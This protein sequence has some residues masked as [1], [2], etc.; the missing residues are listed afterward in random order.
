MFWQETSSDF[1]GCHLL[2]PKKKN[3]FATKKTN[4][5]GWVFGLGMTFPVQLFGGLFHKPWNKDPVMKQPVIIW[6][7]RDPGFFWT[8][9][10]MESSGKKLGEQNLVTMGFA[11]DNNTARWY[12][13]NDGW[14]WWLQLLCRCRD[15]INWWWRM[16]AFVFFSTKTTTNVMFFCIPSPGSFASCWC[17]SIFATKYHIGNQQ[18]H[19]EGTFHC[20]F[21]NLK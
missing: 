17:G 14:P 19:V 20:T 18:K 1:Y 15:L 6:K 16:V 7:V 2:A 3:T 11:Q 5:V 9:A 4:L 13:A 21:F 12:F 10:H 8:V